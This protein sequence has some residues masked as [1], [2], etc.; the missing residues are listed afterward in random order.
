MLG[1]PTGRGRELGT[2]VECAQASSKVLPRPVDIRCCL[3]ASTC[4]GLLAKEALRLAIQLLNE[5][6]GQ[7][8]S[9]Q[10]LDPSPHPKLHQAELQE[11]RFLLAPARRRCE[12]PSEV[13]KHFLSHGQVTLIGSD[14]MSIISFVKDMSVSI[15]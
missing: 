15:A 6:A 4:K 12:V 7:Q 14:P 9:L 11:M 13:N 1:N 8:S 10:D 3:L 2:S 5:L